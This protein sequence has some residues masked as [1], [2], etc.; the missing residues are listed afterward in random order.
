M[1]NHYLTELHE[2]AGNRYVS[3]ISFATIYAALGSMDKAFEWMD[4]SF[5]EGAISIRG[6]KTD[7]IY[8][9]MRSDPRFAELLRRA[10]LTN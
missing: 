10:G 4:K 2:M 8:D 9:K 3:A 5:E 7:P 6:L 1:A